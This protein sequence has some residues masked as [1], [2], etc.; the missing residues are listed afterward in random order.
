MP[1]E[2]KLTEDD[3]P[4]GKQTFPEEGMSQRELAARIRDLENT[5]AATRAGLPL[6]LLP[7]HGAGPGSEV[8]ETWS[9]AEQEEAS[10]E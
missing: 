10:R 5:L 9:Q 6:S 4:K 3:E 7:V 1:A 2:R 8:A